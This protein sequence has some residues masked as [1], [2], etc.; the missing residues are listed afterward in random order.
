MDI[1]HGK[2]RERK[3]RNRFPLAFSK[4]RRKCINRVQLFQIVFWFLEKK[5]LLTLEVLV[6]VSE[7]R[8]VFINID[9]NFVRT[10]AQDE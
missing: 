4:N 6:D 1:L 9:A 5:G 8:I 7:N 10:F 3:A 2:L